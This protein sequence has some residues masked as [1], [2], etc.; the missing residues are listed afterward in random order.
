MP[1]GALRSGS[2]ILAHSYQ[3]F[4]RGAR[5]QPSIAREHAA[6]REAAR[7]RGAGTVDRI[8]QPIVDADAAMKPH[9][10]IDAGNRELGRNH[11]YAMRLERSIEQVKIRH[12]GQQT[13][14]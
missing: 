2:S 14:V 5:D 9:R 1:R 10:M 12:I 7:T 11:R 3:A 4:L 13:A 8:Q 6:A